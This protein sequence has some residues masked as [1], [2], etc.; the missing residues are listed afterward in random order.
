[1][2]I[3]V[4]AASSGQVPEIYTQAAAELGT[5]LARRGHVLVNGA[6]RT[7][8]MGATIDA[9]LSEGGRA[10]GII[11]Q[12]MIDQGWQHQQMS[13]LIVTP[14]MH[15]RKEQMAEM[16][17]A[18]IACPG[19]VGTL[20]ELLEVITWKQLGLYLK[21][22]VVLNTADYYSPLLEQLAR[23]A[24]QQFMRPVHCDIWRVATTPDEAIRLCEETPLWDS[25][26]RRFAAL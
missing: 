15:Q 19:G 8:L 14:D 1:M 6:G 20:E 13:Q 9:A 18:C 11:P 21:P 4:Y 22:I 7:G 2:H 25:S 5:L 3:T 16:A 23:C 10:V 12:F 24:D 26:V 17:D